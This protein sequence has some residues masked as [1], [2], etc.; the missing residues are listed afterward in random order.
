MWVYLA[1]VIAISV[2]NFLFAYRS[3]TRDKYLSYYVLVAGT[4]TAAGFLL[5]ILLIGPFL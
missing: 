4:I 5:Y 1:V 3:Y 2:L